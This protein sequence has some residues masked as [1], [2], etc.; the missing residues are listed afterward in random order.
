MARV[1]R[2][3]AYELAQSMRIYSILNMHTILFRHLL[4]LEIVYISNKFVCVQRRLWSESTDAQADLGLRCG[5]M[6]EA[7]FCMVQ[8]IGFLDFYCI[9][10]LIHFL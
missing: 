3:S 1:K 2:K 5:H 7:R 10:S 4:S 8:P 9:E 6:P